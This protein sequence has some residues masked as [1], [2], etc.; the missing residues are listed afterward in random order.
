MCR[1]E[2]E[3][4][5]ARELAL[6]E[7]MHSLR[8]ELARSIITP[9]VIF[10]VVTIIDRFQGSNSEL[11]SGLDAANREKHNLQSNLDYVKAHSMVDWVDRTVE[12]QVRGSAERIGNA[13]VAAI[14]AMASHPGSSYPGAMFPPMPPSFFHHSLHGTPSISTPTPDTAKSSENRQQAEF[15]QRYPHLARNVL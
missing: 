1:K 8:M 4:A 9:T 7:Q 2:L 10:V 11:A 12:H 3:E 6:E 5:R 14:D 15:S 13:H